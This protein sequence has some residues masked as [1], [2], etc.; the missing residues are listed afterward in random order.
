MIVREASG[1]RKVAAE[2]SRFRIVCDNVPGA[3]ADVRGSR[4]TKIECAATQGSVYFPSGLG[5]RLP[6]SSEKKKRH[7]VSE[8]GPA[9]LRY[10]RFTLGSVYGGQVIPILPGFSAPQQP[11]ESIALDAP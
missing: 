6:V 5:Y 4:V 9:C 10:L 2:P 3:L 1:R 8:I 7:F 11:H